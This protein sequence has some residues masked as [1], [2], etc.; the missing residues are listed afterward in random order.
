M[1]PDN[2]IGPLFVQ[3]SI[4]IGGIF[5]KDMEQSLTIEIGNLYQPGVKDPVSLAADLVWEPGSSSNCSSLTDQ[6]L[7]PRTI[8]VW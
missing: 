3:S 2:S 4:L 7:L 5:H 8:V 6:A 1:L